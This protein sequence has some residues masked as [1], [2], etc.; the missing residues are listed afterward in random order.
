MRRFPFIWN[1]ERL[2]PAERCRARHLPA[3]RVATRIAARVAT[4]YT[5]GPKRRREAIFANLCTLL[6]PH[7]CPQRRNSVHKWPNP[8][9]RGP[10]LP[11]VYT[12]VIPRPPTT[13]AHGATV[14]TNGPKRRRGAIFA[15]LCTLLRPHGHP[16][17]RA[18]PRVPRHR[19][20]HDPRDARALGPETHPTGAVTQP[21]THTNSRSLSFGPR[22]PPQSLSA[23][24]PFCAVLIEPKH[25]PRHRPSSAAC[26]RRR[27]ASSAGS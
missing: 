2:R 18:G 10:I 24:S 26:A 16:H 22:F 11:F 4:V 15:N 12:I 6:R 9:R 21:P 8:V 17:G 13:Q 27:S 25:R 1:A 7:V 19:R 23:K 3:A 5:N 14:Y 20:P